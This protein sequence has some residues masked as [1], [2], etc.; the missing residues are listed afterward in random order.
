MS[1]ISTLKSY[2]AKYGNITLKELLAKVQ[3]NRVHKCPKCNGTG[4]EEHWEYHYPPGMSDDPYKEYYYENCP[5]CKG[6][7]Y[8]ETEFKPK[9]KQVGWE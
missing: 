4:S 3:G 2:Q 6:Y 7:G 8:T 9:M 5:L 1:R